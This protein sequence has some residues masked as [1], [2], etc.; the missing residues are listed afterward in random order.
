MLE[1]NMNNYL[2][3]Y[4]LRSILFSLFC[5]SKFIN[6]QACSG[7]RPDINAP[8]FQNNCRYS[9]TKGKWYTC[10]ETSDSGTNKT[11]FLV[12]S[13]DNCMFSAYCKKYFDSAKTVYGTNE[14]IESCARINDAL[15][16]K[17]Y[18]YGDYCIYSESNSDIFNK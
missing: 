18:D 8:D 9:V 4:L 10:A 14:C 2:L 7:D 13:K 15:K 6:C 16:G 11:Y 1:R 12:D 17:F 5:F 3:I